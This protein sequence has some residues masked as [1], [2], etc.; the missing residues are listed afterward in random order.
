[1]AHCAAAAAE[2]GLTAKEEA[3]MDLSTECWESATPAERVALAKRLAK[4]LP[5]GFTF[6]AI[7]RFRLGEWQH[8][9]ALYQHDNATFALVPSAVA[10]LG[11]DAARPGAWGHRRLHSGIEDLP[12]PPASTWLQLRIWPQA[13]FSFVTPPNVPEVSERCEIR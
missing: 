6:Q 10:S 9:I 13:P 3:G 12:G 8:Q 7:R 2:R 4:Q 11:Y 5:S 1:M